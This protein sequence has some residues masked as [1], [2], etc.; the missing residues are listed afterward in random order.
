[1]L[2]QRKPD[3]NLIAT[4]EAHSIHERCEVA[5]G[6]VGLGWERHIRV[7]ARNLRPTGVGG[8]CG[9]ASKACEGF[10]WRARAQF[11]DLVRLMLAPYR[12]DARVPWPRNTSS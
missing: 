5:F 1:M 2:Q 6:L 3:D 11:R 12:A 10:G 8:L 9:D 4:G 7:D